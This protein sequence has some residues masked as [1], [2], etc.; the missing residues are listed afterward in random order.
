MITDYDSLKSEIALILARSDVTASSDSVSTDIQL[1]ETLISRKLRT[2][3]MEKE[4]TITLV[5]GQDYI[6]LETDFIALRNLEFTSTP[7]NIE[8]VP[9]TKL[10]TLII[11]EGSGRPR[12]FAIGYNSANN[13]QALYFSGTPD[14]AYTLTLTYISKIPA[15]SDG[16]TTNWLIAYDPELYLNAV[17]YFAFRRLRNPIAGEYLQLT[18]E[19]INDMN[20][21]D[22]MNKMGPSGTRVRVR[23]SV[24]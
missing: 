24:V 15:L 9:L 13:V 3:Q 16:N 17:L 23:G 12:V 18:N 4:Q 21:E 10:K 11:H 8:F 20:K 19:R 1:A 22:Q 14:D 7:K 2:T 5:A 6:D